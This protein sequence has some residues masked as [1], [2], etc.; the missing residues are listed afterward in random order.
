MK[1][2][3]LIAVTCLAVLATGCCAD[4]PQPK[5][6]HVVFV[7]I[8]GLAS[9]CLEQALDGT[10]TLSGEAVEIPHIRQ[11]MEG[12]AYTLRKRSVMPSASAINWASIF[13]GVP[14]EMHGYNAWNSREPAIPAAETGINGMP[15]T[16]YTLLRA[17]R[18]E[19]VSGAQYNWDGIGYVIDT[20]AAS[21]HRFDPTVHRDPAYT[22]AAYTARAL[23]YLASAQ[24][25][26][27]TLYYDEL[28][29]A[30]H[31]TGWGSDTYYSVLEELDA[32]IGQL[33]DGLREAGIW[34]DTLLVLSSDHG[35]KDRG[36]G[37]FTIEELEAPFIVYGKPVKSTG[38]ITRT[39]MQ[40]DV[41]ANFA[42]MLGLDI[43][44]HWRGRP[45]PEIFK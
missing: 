29:A 23:E 18:P 31:G 34:D 1:T 22:S 19:A 24:P 15:T 5:A 38:A 27:F 37:G 12:G 25:A 32:C 11:M 20:L 10:A 16:V 39:M 44:D 6:G 2:Q 26:F 43:P 14:T 45:F 7:G 33:M 9:W 41:A 8:D 42:Y 21:W 36:H 40:Y 4:K 3:F 17:Q 35:G 30:G 13:N 28:D